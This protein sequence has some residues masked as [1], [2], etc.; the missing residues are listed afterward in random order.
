MIR[1]QKHVFRLAFMVLSV[2]YP[3]C[4]EAREHSWWPEFTLPESVLVS[5]PGVTK[6]EQLIVQS[7]SGLINKAV[8]Q[9]GFEVGMWVDVPGSQYEYYFDALRS[10]LKG[11]L[12]R[13]SPMQAL[14]WAVEEGI[15]RSYVSYD[16]DVP[17][18]VNIATVQ[19]G[20]DNAVI[21]EKSIE[22][23]VADM[24]GLSCSFDATDWSPI[25][26]FRENRHRLNDRILF[27][28]SPS[29]SNN[30]DFA[31]TTGSMVYYGVDTALEE[32]LAW[33]K[34][35]S[36][37]I[38]WNTGPESAHIE[39][40]S[41]YGLINTVSDFCCN[42]PLLCAIPAE[43]TRFERFDPGSIDYSDDR[44]VHAYVMSDG[45]NLQWTANKMWSSEEYWSSP[46]ATKLK[47]NFTTCAANMYMGPGIVLQC[48]RDSRQDGVTPVEFGGGYYYPDLFARERQDR[49][50]LIRRLALIVGDAMRNCGLGVV[51]FICK[52]IRC[53]ASHEFYRIFAEVNPWLTGMLALQYYPYNAGGGETIW[54]DNGHGVMIPVSTPAGQI[55]AGLE[56]KGSGT[57]EQVASHV[58]T[59]SRKSSW[60]VVHAWSRFAISPDGGIVSA[61][62]KD[63]RNP[64]GV[65]PVY[66]GT[67]F[68][69]KTIGLRSIEEILWRKRMEKFPEQ[70][71]RMLNAITCEHYE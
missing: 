50:G 17:E 43:H 56:I 2:L 67:T 7:L 1:R 10:S 27:L 53:N 20:F 44:R 45:D 24:T 9:D 15:V 35:L 42:L 60:T 6:P 55:W 13:K 14:K 29:I 37:V 66:W 21:V 58:N 31:I 12:L 22:S 38:G 70:T 71:R 4:M 69:D 47:M 63:A 3:L 64:R 34:P 68:L 36:P 65:E 8:Q 28:L 46:Y 16:E 52:D 5:S 49:A 19:A 11:N 48:M 39:P 54:V 59:I 32:I 51:A 23:K 61:S 57:P 41:R 18:S 26:Y 33:C 30:R 25:Q 40:C 62:Q